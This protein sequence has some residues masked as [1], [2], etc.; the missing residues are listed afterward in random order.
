MRETKAVASLLN[1]VEW[2]D[3]PVYKQHFNQKITEKESLQGTQVGVR[4]FK[5]A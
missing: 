3:T 1:N 4:R 2:K 5:E